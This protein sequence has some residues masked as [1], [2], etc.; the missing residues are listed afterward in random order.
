MYSLKMLLPSLRIELNYLLFHFSLNNSLSLLNSSVLWD[1]HFV[2][3]HHSF[4]LKNHFD[5]L[6]GN[7][8]VKLLRRDRRND[9]TVNKDFYR[10]TGKYFMWRL[11]QK[12]SL[13]ADVRFIR[14][15]LMLTDKLL[16]WI[17]RINKRN[18]F[19]FLGCRGWALNRVIEIRKWK[20]NLHWNFLHL[21]W[22]FD[23]YRPLNWNLVTFVHKNLIW[24][25]K[26]K[27]SLLFAILF[28]RV[29]VYWPV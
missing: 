1:N 19:L 29:L 17:R 6:L 27:Y 12:R 8:A 26:S 25:D 16:H 4:L 23:L 13:M 14:V 21:I 7:D 2:L 5:G 20:R 15:W 9:I 24:F 11:D 10:L 28:W 22:S 3:N 18:S